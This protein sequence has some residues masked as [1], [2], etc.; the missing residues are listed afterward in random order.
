M[1]NLKIAIGSD[2]AGFELKE[3]IKQKLQELYL[4][5]Y[6][7]GTYDK[8]RVDY[9]VIAKDIAARVADGKFDRGIIVCGTGIG[10]AIAANKVR[11]IRAANCNDIFCAKMSR[12]HNNANIL[13]LGGRVVGPGLALEIVKTW[14]ETEFEGERHQKRVDMLE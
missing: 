1:K 5:Y 4:E 14:L 8:T 2:H 11:G 13:T 6:D 7:F 9:P 10:V 12:L 3:E